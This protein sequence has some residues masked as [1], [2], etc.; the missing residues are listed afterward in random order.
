MA[1]VTQKQLVNE[2]DINTVL[3]NG[4]NVAELN[5]TKFN[6]VRQAELDEGKFN[7]PQAS[8]I[9][10]NILKP[11]FGNI[12][13]SLGQLSTENLNDFQQEAYI[14]IT[15]NIA[16]YDVTSGTFASYISKWFTGIANDM[17]RGGISNYQYKKYN[18]RVDSL[19]ASLSTNENDNA[20]DKSKEL[21]DETS[22]IEYMLEKKHAEKTAQLMNQ[23]LD[24]SA[25]TLSKDEAIKEQY[26]N[27]ACS[28]L[29][30]GGLQNLP[31]DMRDLIEDL[32]LSLNESEVIAQCL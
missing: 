3:S 27:A 5:W 21:S 13:Y 20:P 22:T 18:I 12:L 25:K 6:E 10:L 8:L 11:A 30:L 7:C 31:E 24:T 4:I 23:I 15:K 9:A 2:N 26:A 17:A 28:Y 1:K 29:L 14:A 32:S 19:D 16:K